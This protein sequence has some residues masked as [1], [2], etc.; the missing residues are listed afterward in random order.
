[1]RTIGVRHVLAVGCLAATIAAMPRC[2]QADVLNLVKVKVRSG[3]LGA[4]KGRISVKGDFILNG[5]ESFVGTDGITVHVADSLTLDQ[6]APE[7][8]TTITCTPANRTLRCKGDTPPFA[9][10]FKFGIPGENGNTAVRLTM[11]LTKL[12][13]EPP[14]SGPI[15]VTLTDLTNGLQLSGEILD[16]RL[17][18]GTINCKE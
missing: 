6:S 12:A 15:A 9:A 13:V 18:N 10:S 7:S 17:S 1:M 14:F 8:A 2:S 11:K 4:A 3:S 5:G 16:C